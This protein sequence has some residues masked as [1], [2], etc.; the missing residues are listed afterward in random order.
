[1]DG[2]FKLIFYIIIGIVW[3]LSNK[4][5]AKWEDKKQNFPKTPQIPSRPTTTPKMQQ[6][7]KSPSLSFNDSAPSFDIFKDSYYNQKLAIKK[8]R[9]EDKIKKRK[10]MDVPIKEPQIIKKTKEPVKA[11]TVTLISKVRKKQSYHLKSNIKEGIIW[12]IVLGP[13]RAKQSLSS[14]NSPMNR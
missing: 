6:P 2:L 5:Q 1:M 7:T 12:S 13:P 10:D 14:M 11:S 9:L 8:K 3:A 4:K